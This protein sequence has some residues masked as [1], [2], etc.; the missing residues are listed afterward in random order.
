MAAG[1]AHFQANHRLFTEIKHAALHV[2]PPR[3]APQ[4][5]LRKWAPLPSPPAHGPA[6]WGQAGAPEAGAYGE[7]DRYPGKLKTRPTLQVTTGPVKNLASEPPL[8][9][10]PS[11][12]ALGLI[13]GG[14]TGGA[15]HAHHPPLGPRAGKARQRSQGTS[16]KPSPAATAETKLRQLPIQGLSGSREAP[17]AGFGWESRWL[18]AGSLCLAVRADGSPTERSFPA[19]RWLERQ[20]KARGKAQTALQL[21]S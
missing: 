5:G 12:N 20:S 1:E 6:S 13:T 8:D 3:A 9:L 10:A 2:A 21:S 16:L 15:G 17:R 19:Q 4:R 14:W 7:R 11:C 18:P